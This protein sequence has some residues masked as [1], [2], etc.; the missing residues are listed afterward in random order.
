MP[1]TFALFLVGAIAICGAPPLNGFSSELLL[2]L[3]LLRA[4]TGNSAESWAWAGFA[5]PALAMIGALAVAGFV[6]V[7]GIAFSGTPRS[8]SSSSAH[9]PDAAML[10]PMLALAAGCIGLGILPSAALPLLQRAVADWDPALSLP[11]LG[12]LLPFGWISLAGLFLLGSVALAA[13]L[14]ARD[15]AP[16]AAALTWDC[17][18]AAPTPRM[19]YVDAS[20][21]ETLV[22]LFDWAVRSRRTP[23]ELPGPFPPPARL[24]IEVLDAVLDHAVLPLAAALDRPLSR[25]RAL[26]RGPVQMYLLYVLLAVVGLLLVAR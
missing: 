15:R 5:V 14:F 3:G 26:Q 4:V 23:P 25:M 10:A 1:R 9:D 11:P 7:A 20:F 24:R 17:G 13:A 18:Y 21:S 8:P 2:Y 19:Q 16:R 12:A 6:K 22:G